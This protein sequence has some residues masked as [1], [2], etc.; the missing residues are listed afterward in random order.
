MSRILVISDSRNLRTSLAG[1]FQ[2]TGYHVHAASPGQ[3]P[4]LLNTKPF[5]LLIFEL[6]TP[7]ESGLKMLLSVRSLYKLP[8]IV[9]ASTTYPEV[10]RRAFL[11]GAWAFLIQPIEPEKIIQCVQ[12][13]LGPNVAQH[14]GA[15]HPRLASRIPDLSPAQ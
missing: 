7:Y 9:L 13:T 2:R 14:P 15:V 3:M 5:D 10:R 1:V 4:H 8:V 6:R 12:Q 11:H